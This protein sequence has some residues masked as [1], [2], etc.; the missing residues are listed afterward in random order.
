MDLLYLKSFGQ[1]RGRKNGKQSRLIIGVY[2]KSRI[3]RLKQGKTCHHL[4]SVL[5]FNLGV[6]LIFLSQEYLIYKLF[7]LLKITNL[8]DLYVNT[9][10]VI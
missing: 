8:F 6:N 7:L 2:C 9:I 3:C 10:K 1:K 4:T 5:F